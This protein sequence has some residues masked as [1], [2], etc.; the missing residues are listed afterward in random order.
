MSRWVVVQVQRR[1][2]HG[3]AQRLH[4]QGGQGEDAAAAQAGGT[5]PA[6]EEEEDQLF[7]GRNN[8]QGNSIKISLILV[9]VQ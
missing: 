5:D 8:F 3:A 7:T 6:P 2:R 4:G 1:W 9:W